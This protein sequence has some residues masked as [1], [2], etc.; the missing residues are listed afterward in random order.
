MTHEDLKNRFKFHPA[1]TLAE[2]EAHEHVR[3]ACFELAEELDAS[4]P[5]GREKIEA[6]KCLEESMFW[7]NAAIARARGDDE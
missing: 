6:I 4:L 1:N 2:Q 5:E 3:E 7:S